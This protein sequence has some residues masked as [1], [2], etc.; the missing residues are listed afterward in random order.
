MPTYSEIMLIKERID[1]N[2]ENSQRK[3]LVS[4]K[5]IYDVGRFYEYK[6]EIRM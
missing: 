1:F 2:F 3:V 6:S 4:L 5:I